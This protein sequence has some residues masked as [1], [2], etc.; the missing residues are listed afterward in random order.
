MGNAKKTVIHI[1]KL[2][3]GRYLFLFDVRQFLKISQI[4]SKFLK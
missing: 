1:P 4:Y 3:V 2:R